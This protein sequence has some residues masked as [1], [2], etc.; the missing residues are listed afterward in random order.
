MQF[1]EELEGFSLHT[2]V[3]WIGLVLVS[4]AISACGPDRPGTGIG[5]WVW[6]DDNGDGIQD[7]E[8]AGIAHVTVRLYTE[9]EDMVDETITNED[10]WFSFANDRGGIYFLEFV[11][12]QGYSFTV[13]N[14]GNILTADSD[15]DP[16]TGRTSEFPLGA[17]EADLSWDA[18][19]V[20]NEV[21]AA[22][23]PTPTATATPT[24]TPNPDA[25]LLDN[26]IL[27][28]SLVVKLKNFADSGVIDPD[29]RFTSPSLDE[30]DPLLQTVPFFLVDPMQNFYLGFA[31]D[32]EGLSI[33]L[34][35]FYPGDPSFRPSFAFNYAQDEATAPSFET[36]NRHFG[37]DPDVLRDTEL[38]VSRLRIN[39]EDFR[40]AEALSLWIYRAVFDEE[41]EFVGYKLVHVALGEDELNAL[42]Q[43]MDAVSDLEDEDL[44]DGALQED[45][46]VGKIYAYSGEELVEVTL[47]EALDALDEA[48][49]QGRVPMD[50]EVRR[51]WTGYLD[52]VEDVGD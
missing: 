14:A 17:G 43:E 6:L 45:Y 36:E 40:D 13:Q 34:S 33:N 39:L 48:L 35:A 19:L 21:A 41:M 9:S 18:G 20:P 27:K 32:L 44:E 37:A 16:N 51:I 10:G 3:M 38:M 29:G 49:L 1:S 2:R 12:P 7:T 8:E 23:T 5:D 28:G 50:P 11:A 52:W 25:V 24:A 31:G 26:L 46:I 22:W 4:L 15:A 30:N 47:G 42:I